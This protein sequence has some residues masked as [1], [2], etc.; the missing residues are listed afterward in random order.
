MAFQRP[1]S[2]STISLRISSAPGE[3]PG[4]RVVKVWMPSLPSDAARRF[5][6][7]DLPV[8]SPPS[9]VMKR[10]VFIPE[11]SFLPETLHGAGQ[12]PEDALLRHR[13]R[14]K[15]RH[16]QRGEF[17]RRDHQNANALSDMD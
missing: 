2:P 9:S 16:G 17:R 8:P 1:G 7:V 10:P 15:D 12:P 6:W 11:I 13:F 3:P 4:S 14:G 5:T